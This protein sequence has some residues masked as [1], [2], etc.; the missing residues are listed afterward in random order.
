MSELRVVIYYGCNNLGGNLAKKNDLNQALKEYG[1]F[2]SLESPTTKFPGRLTTVDNS[3]EFHT[4]P[5]Y[6]PLTSEGIRD[7][8]NQVWESPAG[9]PISVLHGTVA[10]K[11]CTLLRL[12]PLISDGF[13]DFGNMESV[14]SKRYR[15]SLCVLGLHVEGYTADVIDSAR[16]SY[17]AL[18]H[19][20]RARVDFTPTD[21]E[22]T[23]RFSRNA[24]PIVQGRSSEFSFSFD[25]L[26]ELRFA[27]GQIRHRNEAV[28][29]IRP[30]FP[31]S[32]DW[33]WIVGYRLQNFFELVV[34]SRLNVRSIALK[35]SDEVGWCRRN[36]SRKTESIAQN[37]CVRIG[38]DQLAVTMNNWLALPDQFRPFESLLQTVRGKHSSRRP[39]FLS[40]AQ[41][42]ESFH[43]LTSTTSKRF[44]SRE[45][46]KTSSTGSRQASL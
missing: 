1:V 10:G 8:F 13:N 6:E 22:I 16:F 17:S 24:P 40:I 34:G 19:W 26:P 36:V 33:F 38:A 37:I 35:S 21:D 3:I 14:V 4:S 30:D 27:N 32:L 46:S 9:D 28:V 42:L 25:I 41:P 11:P 7:I 12:H 23:I 29:E 43:R 20:I 18:K 15:V 44:T 39:E 45:R 2:W 31:K 5:Q